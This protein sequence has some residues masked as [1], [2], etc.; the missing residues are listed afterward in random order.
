[1]NNRNASPAAFG[2][3]FQV[4]AAILLM[5]E[6]IKEA[7]RVRWPKWKDIGTNSVEVLIFVLFFALFFVVC[8]FVVTFVLRAMGIGA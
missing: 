3:D 2:W 7:K 1:M 5:L 8:E 4:N 6:N